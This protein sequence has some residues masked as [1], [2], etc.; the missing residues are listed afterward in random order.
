[1]ADSVTYVLRTDSPD[2]IPAP[3]SIS[4]CFPD[5]ST[6]DV[7]AALGKDGEFTTGDQ[8]EINML[9]ASPF[10]QRKPATKAK[11]SAPADPKE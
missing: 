11:A 10:L 3:T 2:L 6:F 1:M 7:T 4:A 8:A 9:D 5:G